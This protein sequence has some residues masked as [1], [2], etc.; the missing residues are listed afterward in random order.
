MS[1]FIFSVDYED[2]DKRVIQASN[3]TPVLID[4][5]AD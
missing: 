2:F 3:T 4:L 5:W 1:D